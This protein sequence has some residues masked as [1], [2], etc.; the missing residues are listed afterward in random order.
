MDLSHICKII[1]HL[2]FQQKGQLGHGLTR[3]KKKV[4]FA[5]GEN[6]TTKTIAELVFQAPSETTRKYRRCG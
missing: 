2:M 3:I 5:F 6:L 1:G 4:C